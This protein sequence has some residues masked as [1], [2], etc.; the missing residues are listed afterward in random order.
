MHYSVAT[1]SNPEFVDLQICDINPLM[2]KCTIKVLYLG[3]NRNGSVFNKEIAAKMAKTLRGAPIVG[4][5]KEEKGDFRDHGETI[6]IEDGE[7]KFGCN[8]VPYGFVSPDAK[9]WFQDYE[10]DHSIIRTYLCTT[11]YIWTGQFPESQVAIDEGRPHSMELDD[12]TLKGNWTQ[13]SHTGIDFFIVSDAVFSKLCILGEDVEPCFEGSSII[14]ASPETDF[15]LNNKQII[16]TVFSLMN[17]IKQ[18]IEGGNYTMGN[19]NNTASVTT[20]VVETATVS[21]SAPAADLTPVEFVDNKNKDKEDKKENTPPTKE[22]EKNEEE[23]EKDKKYTIMEQKYTEL[24][25]KYAILEQN[26]NELK[27]FKL[28]TERAEKTAII[29]K[30]SMLTDEDKK[31]VIAKIDSYSASDIEKELAFIAYKKGVS[32][33]TK[34]T[35]NEVAPVE[36]PTSFSLA[37]GAGAGSGEPGWLKAVRATKN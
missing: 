2:S 5:Y 23:K 31:D 35:T 14:G 21:E 33:I 1:L 6:T 13:N 36:V 37:D 19:Q 9:V 3:E 11:G 10:D 27:A 25:Q 29:G 28:N 15:S 30:F 32:T 22:E 34:E 17:T 24:E 20:P 4:Y 16:T 7:I 26:F 12:K 8:T 18:Q